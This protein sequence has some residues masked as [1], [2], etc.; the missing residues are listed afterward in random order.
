MSFSLDLRRFA[1][2][3]R[4]NADQVVRKVTLDIARG[5]VLRTPVDT[6]RAR[7]NWQFGDGQVPTG[8]VGAADPNGTATIAQLAT[9]IDRTK[10]GG[11]TY[12]ANNLPYIL[13]LE[14]GYS[15]QA[16]AGMVR[17]TLTEYQ[18][19]IRNAVAQLSR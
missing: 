1:E 17:T 12:L 14:Y 13:P 18:Q 10:A 4:M 5:V 16:P 15:Q 6:G 2:K 3:A 7:S 9:Q 11:V 19:Y 8:E